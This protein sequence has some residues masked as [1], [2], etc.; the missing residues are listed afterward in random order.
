MREKSQKSAILARPRNV[1]TL[2]SVS[3]YENVCRLVG[4]EMLASGLRWVDQ[5]SK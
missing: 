4:E 5:G 1:E 3:V 2:R